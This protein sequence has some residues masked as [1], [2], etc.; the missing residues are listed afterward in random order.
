MTRQA[1][2]SVRFLPVFA[3]TLVVLAGCTRSQP[4]AGG[5]TTP[6]RTPSPR[7][8]TGNSTTPQTT[9]APL[10]TTPASATSAPESPAPSP[11]P[12]P[13]VERVPYPKAPPAPETTS[14]PTVPITPLHAVQ[15]A[16]L[17][18]PE[19]AL[20]A[21]GSIWVSGHHSRTAFRVD[22]SN[23][24][25]LARIPGIGFH[26]QWPFAGGG[27]V[28]FPGDNSLVAIDPATNGVVRRF[29]GQVASG[30]FAAGHPWVDDAH[31]SLVELDPKTG[32]PLLRLKS[33]SGFPEDCFNQVRF[34]DGSVWWSVQDAGVV[35]RIDPASGHVL[36]TISGVGQDPSEAAFAAG[37]VWV[38]SLDG[39]VRQIDPRT[40]QV[41]TVTTYASQ[42]PNTCADATVGQGDMVWV[43]HGNA[44]L[45]YEFD[46]RTRTVTHV[47]DLGTAAAEGIAGFSQL[48]G[49]AVDGRSLWV[50]LYQAGQV[51]RFDPPAPSG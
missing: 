28:W 44:S 6:G 21:F 22:P 51:Q 3:V 41:T 14:V 11:V 15:T 29:D 7:A 17:T 33:G 13:R 43:G 38:S 48:Q 36:A 27:L 26:A 18:S 24:A 8:T 30:V 25:I 12:K 34:G 40:N 9:P 16:R 5:P 50:P 20:A 31:D 45:L 37:S 35:V 23:G 2:R 4:A 49:I 42:L 19:G 47:D 10:Q 1:S 46:A 39:S 32:A